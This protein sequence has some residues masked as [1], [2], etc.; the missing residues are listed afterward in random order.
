MKNI[1]KPLKNNKANKLFKGLDW[2]DILIAC[3][4]VTLMSAIWI[5]LMI[6]KEIWAGIGTLLGSFALAAIFFLK[7]G[8]FKIYT[9]IY[10][11]IRFHTTKV[12]NKKINFVK[13]VKNNVIALNDTNHN[14]YEFYRI[15]GK[16]V[17]LLNGNDFN[18]LATQLSYF[19]KDHPEINLLKIDGK[20]NLNKISNHIYNLNI[21]HQN[22][23]LQEELKASISKLNE[24]K[25]SQY[26]STQ[27]K[28]FLSFKKTALDV[29]I[30]EKIEEI[31]K[32]LNA[33]ELNLIPVTD[34][35]MNDIQQRLYFNNA[36]IN[37]ENK[38]IKIEYHEHYPLTNDEKELQANLVVNETFLFRDQY[39][40]LINQ[41]N[42]EFL[43]FNEK[44]KQWN[45]VANPFIENKK[46]QK[47]IGFIAIK[48]LPAQVDGCWLANLFNIKGLD[49]N[50]KLK[51]TDMKNLDRELTR[52]IIACEEK[53]NALANNNAIKFK[54]MEQELAGYEA[55]ANALADGEEIKNI[56][57]LIK[58]EKD[59]PS[60]VSQTIRWIAKVLKRQGFEF[61][62]L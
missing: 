13:E 36:I 40:C 28:Y 27:P 42:K 14:V 35:E 46:K 50:L 31:K 8:E 15:I 6:N 21:K 18:Y 49:I 30:K 10:Q 51:N 48:A 59:S 47:Y 11:W 22:S 17:S 23:L 41:Q 56:S 9:F 52:V 7:I 24:L 29:D 25:E 2:K 38:Y 55:L 32:E 53:L 54:K 5:P 1:A 43:C 12:N 19:F 33:A 3:V 45:K 44:N 61:T 60:E 4:I 16:D 34:D 57:C 37:E 62:R 20:I 39:Y 26:S 58:V